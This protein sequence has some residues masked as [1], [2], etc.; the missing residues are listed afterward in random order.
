MEAGLECATGHSN[1]GSHVA[2]AMSLVSRTWCSQ[3]QNPR[4]SCLCAAS[5]GVRVPTLTTVGL[6]CSCA[7]L[8][9]RWKL[10]HP[11]CCHR[12]L[13]WAGSTWPVVLPYLRPPCPAGTP[14]QG[15]AGPEAHTDSPPQAVLGARRGAHCLGGAVQVVSR[16]LSVGV[17]SSPWLPRMQWGEQVR[18][19]LSGGAGVLQTVCPSALGPLSQLVVPSA[20]GR[21]GPV[22]GRR[23]ACGSQPTWSLSAYA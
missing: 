11:A 16:P 1:T 13:S 20:E 22:G 12:S 4:D 17:V 9:A 23:P 18:Q 5:S 6:F 15:D 7:G 2:G 8:G 14:A 3:L 10:A 21:G 19:P